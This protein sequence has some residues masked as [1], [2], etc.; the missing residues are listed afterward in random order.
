MSI[1][2]DGQGELSSIRVL[3]TETK[4]ESDLPCT[5]IL[6]AAGA[7]SPQVF[8]T[9]FPTS[10]RKLPLSSLAGYSLVVQTPSWRDDKEAGC[11]AV[12]TTEENGYCPEI[13]SRAFGEIYI[14]GLNYTSI[15]LPDLPGEAELDEAAMRTLEKTAQ[16]I[17]VAEKGDQ[18]EVVRKGLCFSTCH[19][20]RDAYR[21]KDFRSGSGKH[22]N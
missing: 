22:Q 13:F 12:F 2:E 21:R 20:K 9:L 14:A 10:K 16:K 11:H 6:I 17:L 15:P 1:A 3:D 19:C 4:I 7:W 8:S 18:L 5:S